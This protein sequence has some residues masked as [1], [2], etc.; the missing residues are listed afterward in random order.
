MEK[1]V[2]GLIEKVRINGVELKA[3]IDTG[4]DRSSIC[5][6]MVDELNLEP[7]GKKVKV[8]SSHGET[9]REVYSANLE[10]KGKILKTEFTIIDRNNLNYGILIGK[11]TLKHG[12]LIDPSK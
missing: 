8:R 1:I 12:F 5:R 7:T 2:L 11:N 9:K 6:S 10:I 4:A 3:K